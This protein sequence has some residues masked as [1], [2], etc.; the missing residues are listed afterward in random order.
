MKDSSYSY[1]HWAQGNAFFCLN[2]HYSNNC[3]LVVQNRH[4]YLFQ[5]IDYVAA[6]Q[7]CVLHFNAQNFHV[8]YSYLVAYIFYVLAAYFLL[9]HIEYK[10]KFSAII[11]IIIIL[12]RFNKIK[13][14]TFFF[15]T[16]IT[17][18][19]LWC[20]Y[21]CYTFLHFILFIIPSSSSYALWSPSSTLMSS[22]STPTWF[23]E[24]YVS[25]ANKV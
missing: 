6:Y 12:V 8:P 14:F 18:L 4:L 23:S 3:Y 2:F 21:I 11:I 16:N 22:S 20:F 19:H 7:W 13:I 15:C 5:H 9:L 25:F 17:I 24:L 10:Q 1:L